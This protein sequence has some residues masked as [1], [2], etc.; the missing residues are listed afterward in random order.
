[1]IDHHILLKLDGICGIDVGCTNVK[2]AAIVDGEMKT[3]IIPSGD[4]M[5]KESLISEIS[6]FYQCFETYLAGLGIAFSGSTTNGC[7]VSRTSLPCLEGLNTMDFAHL[8]DSVS[9][10]NDAN[11]AAVAGYL[12]YPDAKVLVGITNG[13]GIGAGIVIDG[14]LF[15]GASGFSG[16]IYG[17]RV[18]LQ[19]NP[20]KVGKLCSGSKILKKLQSVERDS[21]DYEEIIDSASEYMGSTLISIIHLLNPDVIYFSGGGFY[22]KDYLTKTT[23]FVKQYAYPYMLDQLSLVEA[24]FDRYT[25]CLGAMQYVYSG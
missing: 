10:I 5:T 25:G 16:E 8:T 21:K 22:F 17:N 9:F 20:V 2:M 15:N 24:S 11:S 14:K 19:G 7:E 12:E 23:D 6:S 18:L 13:T 1:M 3:R 4:T